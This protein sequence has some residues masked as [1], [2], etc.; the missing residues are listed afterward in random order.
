MT[1][2]ELRQTDEVYQPALCELAAGLDNIADDSPQIEWIEAY[3][4]L[5]DADF[6]SAGFVGRASDGAQLYLEV[7][8]NDDTPEREVRAEVKVLASD[9]RFSA[10]PDMARVVWSEETQA[11]NLWLADV[12]R[13]ETA[14][15]G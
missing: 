13:G 10:I 8:C 4:H 2:N 5:V 6:S 14:P 11:L 3:W 1:L 7:H 9:P 15:G 12:L